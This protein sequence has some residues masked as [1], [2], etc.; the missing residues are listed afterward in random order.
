MSCGAGGA[1]DARDA[2]SV[3]EVIDVIFLRVSRVRDFR[4]N[5]SRGTRDND[6]WHRERGLC[7]F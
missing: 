3:I 6:G 4:I 1:T 5:L 2:R 7:R